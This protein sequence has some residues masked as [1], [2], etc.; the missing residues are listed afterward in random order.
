LTYKGCANEV[1]KHIQKL[2]DSRQFRNSSVIA[3]IQFAIFSIER[4]HKGLVLYMEEQW[5]FKI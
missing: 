5:G 3:C 1:W 4:S 2:R